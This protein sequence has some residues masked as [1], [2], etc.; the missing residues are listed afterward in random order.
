MYWT[1]IRLLWSN[2]C[3]KTSF[4][5]LSGPVQMCVQQLNTNLLQAACCSEIC[6]ISSSVRAWIFSRWA[7]WEFSP[8]LFWVS[9]RDPMGQSFL[10]KRF[11]GSGYPLVWGWGPWFPLAA[12]LPS[13]WKAL[14]CLLLMLVLTVI[15][16][17]PGYGVDVRKFRVDQPLEN[18]Q[19]HSSCILSVV[20]S[21]PVGKD[22]SNVRFQAPCRP[23]NL[24]C[25]RVI[26]FKPSLGGFYAFSCLLPS[27]GLLPSN[28]FKPID[29]SV[30][31]SVTTVWLKTV[32]M[33]MLTF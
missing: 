28:V 31:V 13:V 26:L 24:G 6:H 21:V 29:S 17:S 11:P 1:Y 16:T 4:C 27:Q 14:A 2:V 3:V 9:A 18:V 30:A 25:I 19:P 15:N 5:F 22:E 23:A 32:K 7:Q 8:C 12:A 33:C 20:G 10:V